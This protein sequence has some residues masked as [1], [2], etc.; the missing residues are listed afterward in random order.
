M[1]QLARCGCVAADIAGG[2]N[3][4][5]S[6]D[7]ASGGVSRVVA[8]NYICPIEPAGVAKVVVVNGIASEIFY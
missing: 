7:V 5:V 8:L 4:S 1:D 6:E 2:F 3:L